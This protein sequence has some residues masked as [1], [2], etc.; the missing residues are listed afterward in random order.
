MSTLKHTI[1][2]ATLFLGMTVTA[3][4]TD[5]IR[6]GAIA[7]TRDGRV[8]CSIQ[9][10]RSEELPGA[11]IYQNRVKATLLVNAP[12]HVPFETTVVRLIPWQVPPPRQG[13]R[14]TMLC[15]P[16]SLSFPIFF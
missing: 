7:E 2:V 13:Q 15:D 6:G 10:L 12:G 5:P 1:T 4:G 3:L 11:P 16:E 8:R 9:V 14:L